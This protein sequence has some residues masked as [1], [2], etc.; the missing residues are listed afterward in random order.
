MW[1]GFRFGDAA[2]CA[3]TSLLRDGA[4]DSKSLMEVC[5]LLK[6]KSRCPYY[7][8]VDERTYD[9]L[10]LAQQIATRPYMASE[11]LRDMQ[12]KRSLPLRTGEVSIWPMQKFLHL[13]YLYVFEP[14]FVHAFLK[15]LETELQKVILN[16]GR[17]S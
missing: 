6:A 7:V 3:S 5:E 11:I 9:Y 16:C 4:F 13:S 14:Q 10:Q 17:S 1:Q 15:G 12:E 2:K 8:N